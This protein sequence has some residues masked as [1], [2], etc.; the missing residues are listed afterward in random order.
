MARGGAPSPVLLAGVA[1]GAAALNQ[2]FW[3]LPLALLLGLPAL[4]WG[5][6]FIAGLAFA[7]FVLLAWLLQPRQP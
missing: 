5:N 2:L 3:L 1:L 4:W 7:A 6:A